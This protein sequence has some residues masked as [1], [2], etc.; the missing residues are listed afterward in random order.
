MKFIVAPTTLVLVFATAFVLDIAAKA[1]TE[2]TECSDATL[3]GGFGYTATGTL[4]PSA[5][6]GP[7]FWAFR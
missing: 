2:H 6:P 4:L 7:A 1:Q 3:Q 5:A